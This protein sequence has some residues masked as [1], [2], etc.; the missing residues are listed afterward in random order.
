MFQPIKVITADIDILAVCIFGLAVMLQ[1]GLN[2]SRGINRSQQ[3][4]I[5]LAQEVQI[6]PLF[7]YLDF[8]FYQ[9][10]KLLN[11]KLPLLVKTLS[12]MLVK[13][14]YLLAIRFYSLIRCQY[15]FYH[16]SNFSLLSINSF[17]S[18]PRIL[19]ISKSCSKLG[20]RRLQT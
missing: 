17:T 2:Y 3:L 1:I 13:N 7:G 5:T 8:L 10:L 11:I 9:G 14:L 6:I 15:I 4:S 12:E 20:W 16:C 18:T 19:A